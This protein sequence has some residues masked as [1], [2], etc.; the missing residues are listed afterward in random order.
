MARR[1][2]V[3]QREAARYLGVKVHTLENWRYLGK[4]PRFY[5]VGQLVKYDQADLDAWLD[6]RVEETTDAASA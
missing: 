6:G 4:G 1:C 5:R 2:L 3:D